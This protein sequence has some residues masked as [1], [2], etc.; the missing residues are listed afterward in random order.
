MSTRVLPILRAYAKICSSM[1]MLP[2]AL[3]C[4]VAMYVHEYDIGTALAGIALIS[5]LVFVY[6]RRWAPFPF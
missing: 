1:A 5:G 3:L 2:A 4:G 6:L